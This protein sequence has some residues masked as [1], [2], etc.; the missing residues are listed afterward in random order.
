MGLGW[1]GLRAL[2][3]GAGGWQGL[4][5]WRSVLGLLEEPESP[6]SLKLRNRPEIIIPRPLAFTSFGCHGPGL[7]V[8][9]ARV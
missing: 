8:S 1:F 7:R 6:I 4:G 3:L 2:D 9:G 5:L